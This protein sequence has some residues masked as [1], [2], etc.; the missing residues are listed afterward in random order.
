VQNAEL[1]LESK[2]KSMADKLNK[3]AFKYQSAYA[4]TNKSDHR[5]LYAIAFHQH[6]KNR[7]I[8]ATAGGDRANV[9]EAIKI[10]GK[11]DANPIH[12]LQSYR[13][14]NNEE[15]LYTCVW[16]V[17]NNRS[18]LLTGG[19]TGVIRMIDTK[20]LGHAKQ[21]TVHGNSINELQI[22]PRYAEI[23]LSAS[24]DQSVRL[25][26]INKDICIAVFG[27]QNGHFD[28]VLSIDFSLTGDCFISCGMD[29]QLMIWDIEP[30]AGTKLIAQN[31][32]EKE[33]IDTDIAPFTSDRSI[34]G[35]IMQSFRHDPILPFKTINVAQPIFSTNEVHGNYVDTVKILNNL[36][37]SKSCENFIEIWKPCLHEKSLQR[38]MF[39]KSLKM[40]NADIWFMKL[41]ITNDKKLVASGTCNG[42]I[43]VWN[44]T[45]QNPSG[46]RVRLDYPDIKSTSRYDEQKAV[47]QVAFSPDGQVLISVHDNSTLVRWDQVP[48]TK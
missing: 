4:D 6:I 40:V 18:Y 46:T 42:S 12:L 5:Q 41:G 23:M 35:A 33:I 17:V 44:L 13:D 29:H 39:L 24:K 2:K 21:F 30:H 25:W 7:Y 19:E 8:F 22:H 36:I 47:R 3:P 26:N 10:P 32:L 9:Y 31:E 38:P 11:N 34:H 14:P 27:G 48:M 1:G 45:S 20:Q 16:T 37:L 15:K 43:L 28:E